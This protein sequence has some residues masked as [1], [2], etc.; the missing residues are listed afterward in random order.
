MSLK[1]NII[2]NYVSQLYVTGIGILLLPLYI[3]YMGPEA[4]GLVGFFAMLQAWFALMDLG[5]T[6]TI[7][8][9]T[10]RYYGGSMGA[11]AYRRLFRALSSIFIV[12]ALIGGAVLWLLA[13]SIA[14]K[15]LKVDSIPITDVVFAVRI[16][17]ISVALRWMTGL[18][19]GV[20]TGCEQLVWL[21]VVNIV[22]A[23]LRFFGVFVSMWLWGFTPLVFF[24]HQF[25]VAILELLVLYFKASFS[26]PSKASLAE[27]IGF[28][29]SPIKSVLKFSLAI[30][31]TSSIWV[32]VTQTDKLI[33]SGILPLA[34]Y[35]YFTMAVLVASGIMIISSPIS[36]SIMPRMA[37]LHAE[38]KHR[39]LLNVYRNA[40]QLVSVLCGSAAIVIA[41]FSEALLFVWTADRELAKKTS[42]ILTLY[43]IGN[44]FLAVSA[45][46]Y[47]LQYAKGN[48]RYHLIGNAVMAVVLI[49]SIIVA[50]T[51]FGAVGAGYVWL[52]VNVLYLISWAGYVHH[53]LEPS[54]HAKWL[55]SDIFTV[56][57]APALT[58]YGLK[59]LVDIYYTSTNRF[60]E[61][62][63]IITV[64]LL[65]L[66]IAVLSS[67][68]TRVGLYRFISS[69]VKN[70]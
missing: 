54:L 16:M 69:K 9:E 63:L 62:L 49:P 64:S 52:I 5:L 11:L 42:S 29:F 14:S 44:G 45:F 46:P 32:L 31:F 33:L 40:T 56:A 26:L 27:A 59:Y 50:A 20:V 19:R 55:L 65:T 23:T 66:S 70:V 36:S 28:S 25:V 22:I 10:A 6:P 53:K 57:V 47:Y 8:R 1:K 68:Y 37:R 43:V 21:S 13:S 17:A 18:Y 35:G 12:I 58:V 41:F 24:V 39:E 51:Y 15:W 30:A 61:L 67:R 7:S 3:K 4:Y 2:A 34:E 38:G 48:L 60:S